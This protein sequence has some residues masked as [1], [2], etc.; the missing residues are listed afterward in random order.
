MS[1]LEFR[2]KAASRF[3]DDLKC[4]RYSVERPSVTF[5]LLVSKPADEFAD[6]L[7]IVSNID[8]ASRALLESI[9]SFSLGGG[10]NVGFQMAMV[11]DVDRAREQVLKVLGDIDVFPQSNRG[12]RRDID[13]NV[14]VAVGAMVAARVRAEQRRMRDATRAT[15]P[16]SPAIWR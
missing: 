7:P 8:S 4:A 13:Q 5:E 10:P 3:G 14:N 2:R 15:R 12:L 9:H 1:C 11:G 16:H 6:K